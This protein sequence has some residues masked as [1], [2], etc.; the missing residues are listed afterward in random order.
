MLSTCAS[1]YVTQYIASFLRG[2][3][4]W[5]V[6]EYLGGGSCLDLV[7]NSSVAW[8][9]ILTSSVETWPLQRS[10]HCNNMPRT[11]TRTG[12]SPPR[13]QDTQRYQ[14]CQCSAIHRRQGQISGLRCCS[15]THKYKVPTEH[16]RR[17]SL[18]DGSGSDSTEWIRFQ[19]GHM[20]SR[21]HSYRV[22]QWRTSK[23]VDTPYE[24][25]L[26]HPKSTRTEARGFAI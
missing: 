25:S 16:I 2:H 26:P 3:K 18:L 10:P 5:I 19:G 6:M 15:T 12:I 9:I 23:C 24:S 7:G 17:Y 11:S 22:D 14:G 4:L 20:V 8:V 13:R 21:N 1:P